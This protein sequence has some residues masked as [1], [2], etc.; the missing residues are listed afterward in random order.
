MTWL[1]G[2]CCVP[3][4][5]LR[6]LKTMIKR[7]KDVTMIRIDGASERTVVRA[8][9][10]MIRDVVLSGPPHVRVTKIQ[11][12]ALRKNVRITKREDQKRKAGDKSAGKR[13]L[14]DLLCGH[15]SAAP[16]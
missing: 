5:V 2:A 16:V 8:I 11:R 6:K 4:A 3:R 13:E 10:W 15:T 9:N 14:K 1:G 12:K 7:V